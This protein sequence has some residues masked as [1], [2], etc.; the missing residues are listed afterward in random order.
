M[1]FVGRLSH[2]AVLAILSGGVAAVFWSLVFGQAW[3]TVVVFGLAAALYYFFWRQRLKQMNL[4]PNCTWAEFL[5]AAKKR[6]HRQ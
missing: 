3:R 4:D 1:Q 6:Q 5:A 2:S